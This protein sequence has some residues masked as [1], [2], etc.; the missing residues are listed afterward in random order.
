ML[1]DGGRRP[2]P[3]GHDS[4]IK[5]ACSS[6][7][8]Q[9]AYKSLN[10]NA[11]FLHIQ[12]KRKWFYLFRIA[13]LWQS[14]WIVDRP[15]TRFQPCGK[16]ALEWRA[17]LWLLLPALAWTHSHF[18]G[19]ATSRQRDGWTSVAYLRI[20]NAFT[21]R[22]ECCS[23]PGKYSGRGRVNQQQANDTLKL[24]NTRGILEKTGC[25]V[26]TGIPLIYKA[27]SIPFSLGL[28]RAFQMRVV[29]MLLALLSLNI[30]VSQHHL[31]WVVNEFDVTLDNDKGDF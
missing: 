3:L 18:Q 2:G 11:I 17:L 5:L 31:W 25:L 8:N 1:Q 14:S 24:C 27:F 28:P 22:L 26:S 7:A 23:I 6:C 10:P 13:R 30:Y 4:T 15:P 9:S 12:I 29:A 20:Q 16:T 19:S 21:G